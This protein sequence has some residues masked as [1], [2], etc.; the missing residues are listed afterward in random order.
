MACVLTLEQ[1]T[2]YNLG[3]LNQIAA[4]ELLS[5]LVHRPCRRTGRSI[6]PYLAVST[7]YDSVAYL[8]S[9]D[10]VAKDAP[11]GELVKV[12]GGH[13]DVYKGEFSF[14]ENVNAQLSDPSS[15]IP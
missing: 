13:F 11:L 1:Y 8:K 9:A 10:K 2:H 14:D 6:K 7:E 15:V 12:K 5:I 4:R 3:F